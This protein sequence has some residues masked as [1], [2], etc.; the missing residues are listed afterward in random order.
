MYGIIPVPTA[1]VVFTVV[2]QYVMSA[3]SQWRGS[4]DPIYQQQT[5]QSNY[6]PSQ[7]SFPQ[8]A[9]EKV[10]VAELGQGRERS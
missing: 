3:A 2:L 8:H 6:S 4:C 10:E 7:T 9:H 5:E 1:S